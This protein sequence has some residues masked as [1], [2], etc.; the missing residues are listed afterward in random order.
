[1]P[2]SAKVWKN[3]ALKL[4]DQLEDAV[5]EVYAKAL[6][7]ADCPYMTVLRLLAAVK[8]ADAADPDLS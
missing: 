3:M 4:A 8:K 5:A 7:S 2:I 1:M 6:P